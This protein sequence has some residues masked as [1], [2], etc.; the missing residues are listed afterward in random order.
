M[1]QLFIEALFVGIIIVI[2]G[3]IVSLCVAY[4]FKSDLPKICKAWNKNHVMEISLFF[5]GALFHIF[6]KWFQRKR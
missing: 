1:R 6:Y 5:T 2:I 3:S 4:I